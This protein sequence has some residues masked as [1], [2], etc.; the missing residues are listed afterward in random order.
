MYSGN[1]G[2]VNLGNTCYMNSIIQCL[3]HL[4]VFHPKNKKLINDL[5]DKETKLFDQ[6]LALNDS[7]WKN[8][9]TIVST[10]NFVIEFINE[11]KK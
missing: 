4:L 6:W 11:L 1:K 2:L 3:S 5:N 7:L 10:K 8:T 9:N